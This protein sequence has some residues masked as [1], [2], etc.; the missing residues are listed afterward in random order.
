MCMHTKDLNAGNQIGGR[1][2]IPTEAVNSI[3]MNPSPL[4][5]RPNYGLSSRADWV[6]IAST[7]KN[8]KCK[9]VE[10]ATIIQATPFPKNSYGNTRIIDKF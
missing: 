4:P 5:T 8:L 1:V 9:P 2:E 7:R 6:L 10:K 3:R